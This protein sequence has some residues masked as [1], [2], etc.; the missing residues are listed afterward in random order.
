[1]KPGHIYNVPIQFISEADPLTLRKGDGP[2]IRVDKGHESYADAPLLADVKGCASL[3]VAANGLNG[4]GEE[5]VFPTEDP[6]TL[7][8]IFAAFFCH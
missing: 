5:V 4:I 6:N 8:N 7:L 1:M 3:A 2:N